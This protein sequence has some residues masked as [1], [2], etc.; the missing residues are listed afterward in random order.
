MRNSF[1]YAVV[2][3]LIFQMITL[4]KRGRMT[5]NPVLT[6]GKTVLI[7]KSMWNLYLMQ[8]T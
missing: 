7:T 8:V 2:L 6:T 4:A 3:I 1:T 5:A